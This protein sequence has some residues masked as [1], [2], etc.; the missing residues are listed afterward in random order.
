MARTYTEGVQGDGVPQLSGAPGALA[1]TADDEGLDR[2]WTV[3]NLLSVARLVLLGWFCYLLFG[4]HERV[5]AFIVL[6]VTGS[7]DFIDGYVARRFH[8]VTTVG[9][10]LDPT[11]DRVV[12]ATAVIAIVAYGAVPA[13][14]AAVVL[15]REAIV[16]LAVLGL[17]A[18]GAKRIDVLFIG[19]AGTFGLM[20]AFPLFLLSDAS[21]TWAQVLRDISWAIFVPAL[22][23]SL[24]A[25]LSYVPLARR[26]LVDRAAGPAA[27][28]APRGASL[29]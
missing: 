13:W 23:L 10:V 19:K 21:P 12:L 18:L 16:S 26:A 20:V 14:V 24:A 5:G 22:I 3:P 15:G 11:A 9:K 1:G 8:Q 4:D 29:R 6:A 27:S 2:I 7:T 17:A 25:A 28:P